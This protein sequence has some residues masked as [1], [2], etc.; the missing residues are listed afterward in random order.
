[1]IRQGVSPAFQKMDLLRPA[2]ALA[3]QTHRDRVAAH[4]LAREDQDH[5][6]P[7]TG[8]AT[9]LPPRHRVLKSACAIRLG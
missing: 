1:M 6:A 3:A 5:P 9:P 8:A 2:G 7:A 4:R